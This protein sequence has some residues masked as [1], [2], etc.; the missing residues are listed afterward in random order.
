MAGRIWYQIADRGEG[1]ELFASHEEADQSLQRTLAKHQDRG[2]KVEF[3]VDGKG[4]HPLWIVQSQGEVIA[5][6][7][8]I[9]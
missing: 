9:D 4:G 5:K 6:Y 2:H 3:D 1:E 8:L 7:R